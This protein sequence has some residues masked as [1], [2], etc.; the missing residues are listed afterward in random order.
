MDP[1]RVASRAAAPNEE[2]WLVA[3]LFELSPNQ[4][5]DR[6]RQLVLVSPSPR[7]AVTVSGNL[8]H[9]LSDR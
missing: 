5:S 1:L 4:G 7:S 3:T 8:D 6:F 9:G 2:I